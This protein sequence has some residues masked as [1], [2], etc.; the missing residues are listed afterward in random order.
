METLSQPR[1]R[2]RDRAHRIVYSRRFEYAIVALILGSG[3]LLGLDTVDGI[4]E[5]YGTWLELGQQAV[6]AAFIV[7]AA[8]K[9]YA[10]SPRFGRYFRDPW[11]VFDFL[12]I[13][14]SLVPAV[15]VWALVARKVRLLRVLRLVSAIPELRLLVTTLVRSIPGMLHIVA[16][17]GALSYVYAIIGF[18]LFREHDPEHW[19]N[20]GASMLSLF[21]MVT[22]EDWTDIMY[23]AMD[24]H[25][26]ASLYFISF[27]VL[28]AFIIF[29]LF[30]ALVINNL[31]QTRRERQGSGADAV[32][33]ESALLAVQAAYD[34][35]HRLERQLEAAGEPEGASRAGGGAPPPGA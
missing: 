34:A 14:V 12:I 7:E 16:L 17:M 9:L 25:P 15:G 30:T 18:Q 31:D 26:L 23:V 27:V 22:L 35:I 21:R 20:L 10:V 2:A 1:S 13:V 24:L 5:R 33:R 4:V 29:N 32:P 11:N 8:L 19:H 6:L 3:V 28:G